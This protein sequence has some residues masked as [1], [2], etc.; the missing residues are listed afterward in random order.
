[1]STQDALDALSR[2]RRR[3]M[4]AT[5]KAV[6]ERV[7]DSAVNAALHGQADSLRSLLLKHT[8]QLLPVSSAKG[9]DAGDTPLHAAAQGNKLECL[10]VALQHGGTLPQG[11][12]RV[13]S[14]GEHCEVCDAYPPGDGAAGS[15]D[16]EG[17]DTDS[18]GPTH[19]IDI[20]CRNKRSIETPL[21]VACRWGASDVAQALV[22]HGADVHARDVGGATPL[23][24]LC[25]TGRH[26]CLRTLMD[27]GVDPILKSDIGPTPRE[28]CAE[29]GWSRLGVAVRAYEVSHFLSTCRMFVLALARQRMRAAAAAAADRGEADGD[30]DSGSGKEAG[31]QIARPSE[32]S[33]YLALPQSV[34]VCVLSMLCPAHFDLDGAISA[35]NVDRRAKAAMQ[36]DAPPD[37]DHEAKSGEKAG[38]TPQ[39]VAA[40]AARV[41]TATAAAS[42]R[43]SAAHKALEDE[44][45]FRVAELRA[46]R[47]PP[48]AVKALLEAAAMV[49]YL[50]GAT[51][52][53]GGGSGGAGGAAHP[54]FEKAGDHV[55]HGYVKR[56]F[57]GTHSWNDVLNLVSRRDFLA[58][59]KAVPA[60]ALLTAPPRV[61]ARLR[62]YVADRHS[63]AE[64]IS[65]ASR[66]C[67]QLHAWV[68]ALVVAA[69]ARLKD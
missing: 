67:V 37:A 39:Q 47:N 30:G 40:A 11:R 56:L 17:G 25:E 27:A 35:A 1:M 51:L 33:L 20:D 53:G 7:T 13:V 66:A 65:R 19:V 8:E 43:L 61:I 2:S 36:R 18:P 58:R 49:T 29:W 45:G 15:K 63:R 28:V 57:R 10:A 60:D 16:E 21:A 64:R 4:L 31:R 44:E 41:K 14:A 5:P 46:L 34:W 68:G 3:L 24:A 26:E 62:A 23:H 50:H 55:A 6:A 52:D 38:R 59:L 12:C 69:D 22:W 54:W 42:A 9:S 32:P 48:E